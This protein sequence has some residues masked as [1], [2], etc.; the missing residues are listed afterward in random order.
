MLLMAVEQDGRTIWVIVEQHRPKGRIRS[1]IVMHLGEYRD[2]EAAEAAVLRR[3][4]G[5]D[6]LLRAIAERWAENAEDV[7]TDRKA[8]TRF[9]LHGVS[10]GG[11]A[12]FADE[13]LSRREAQERQARERARAA[14]W[15]RGI[16][17]AAFAALALPT[18]ASAAEVKI[19]YRRRALLLHPDRGGDASAMAAL[20]AA[21]E[22]AVWYAEWRG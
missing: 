10:T 14:L 12:A 22:D 8:R 9:L 1:R 13:M 11:I 16:P 6:V 17:S 15:P 7:L 4:Q 18:S 19:A 20:N 2:R 3:L 21:Y 5:G